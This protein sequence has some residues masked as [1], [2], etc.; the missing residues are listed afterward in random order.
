MR[1][2][3]TGGAGFIGSH[4]TDAL[5]AKNHEVLVIDDLS[6]G[7][8]AYVS[9]G[10]ELLVADVRSEAVDAAIRKFKADAVYHE[11]AQID[12]RVSV[13]DPLRD[14]DINVL[15]TARVAKAAL[16]SG[17]STFIFA[18][19]GGAIYGEQDVFPAPESHPTR[20]ESPYGVSKLCAEHYLDYF[21]R[22]AGMRTVFLRYANVYGPRQDP[23]GEAGVVAIFSGRMLDGQAVTIF[24]DG[25]QTRDYVY[26]GDV[27]RA[28]LLALENVE[29]RG[30]YNIGTGRETDVNALA[31]AVA[32]QVHASDQ[33]AYGPA[34]A[35][36]QKRSAL[37]AVRARRELGFI[38]E[39]DLDRGLEHT[40]EW[41]ASLR[42]GQRPSV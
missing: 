23:H 29:A 6:R 15:G 41:F 20:P 4:L 25:K 3:V 32:R 33:F 1:I 10:A 22:T 24:G 7:N 37:D 36:E 30:A 28:N 17:V 31:H 18:S 11:A 27:V 26:V 14:A 40:V 21:G 39:F 8:R 13:A 34:R 5:V 19:T 35:G 16:E 42:T 2:I 12:V 38:P 9:R